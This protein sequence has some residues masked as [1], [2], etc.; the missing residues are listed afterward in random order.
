MQEFGLQS[1]EI[2]SSRTK[3]IT[4]QSKRSSVQLLFPKSLL[5]RRDRAETR[6]VAC[7]PAAQELVHAFAAEVCPVAVPYL[8]AEQTFGHAVEAEVAPVV[9]PQVPAEA[10]DME[11]MG[12][13]NRTCVARAGT[14][15]K[16][17]VEHTSAGTKA[18]HAC[19]ADV[20]PVAAP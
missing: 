18:N 5:T 3:Q 17:D 16:E 2:E 1:K 19:A 7:G 8:P 13:Q 14:A 20:C 11:R 4:M 10:R 12:A 15:D 6:S 9:V